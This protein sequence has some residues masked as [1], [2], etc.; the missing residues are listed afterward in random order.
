[1]H[2]NAVV[3]VSMTVATDIR[4]PVNDKNSCATVFLPVLPGIHRPGQ[5]GAS[6]FYC[7]GK[8]IAVKRN[9]TTHKERL[10]IVNGL[11]LMPKF[12]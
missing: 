7:R 11:Q 2:A 3:V 9:A 5:S 8:D 1:M 12:C 10:L 6:S 4:V